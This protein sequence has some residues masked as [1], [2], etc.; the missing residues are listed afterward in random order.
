VR[1]EVQP[2]IISQA[3]IKS[4]LFVLSTWEGAEKRSQTERILLA[5]ESFQLI[6]VELRS[7]H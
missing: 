7:I 4:C 3:N 5:T 2:T 6:K 1:I